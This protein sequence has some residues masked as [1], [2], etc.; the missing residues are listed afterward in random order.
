VRARLV[1]VDDVLRKAFVMLSGG[2]VD[3]Y[4]LWLGLVA[5][6]RAGEAVEGG[7]AHVGVLAD[8]TEPLGAV[9]F[10]RRAMLLCQA[11]FE[12]L[13][14]GDR[15]QHTQGHFLSLHRRRRCLSRRR[16]LHVTSPQRTQSH[17]ELI[18]KV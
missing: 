6:I 2:A 5:Q 18:H 3:T 11:I 15:L 1:G 12:E 13:Q 14:L 9:V 7:H 4:K 16:N 10:S 17:T 8:L